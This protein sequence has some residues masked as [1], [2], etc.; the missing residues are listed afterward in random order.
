MANFALPNRS[1]KLTQLQTQAAAKQQLLTEAASLQPDYDAVTKALLDKE[2]YSADYTPVADR[3]NGIVSEYVS[4][5]NKDPFYAFTRKGRQTARV[6]KEILNDPA[7]R[8]YEADAKISDDNYKRAKDKNLGGDYL[9]DGNRVAVIRDGK[10]DWMDIDN[11]NQLDSKKNEGVL[12]VDDDHYYTRNAFGVRAGVPTYSMSS[13]KDV[14]DK[15]RSAFANAG[16]TDLQ[17]TARNTSD[18]IDTA[19][20]RKSNRQQLGIM[21]NNLINKE[22]TKEDLNTLKSKYLQSAPNPSNAGFKQWLNDRVISVA[23]GRADTVQENKEDVSLDLKRAKAAGEA[24]LGKEPLSPAH[25]II[26]GFYSSRPIIREEKGTGTF[27]K[28][29]LLPIK[30]TFERSRGKYKDPNGVEYTSRKLSDLDVFSDA[31]DLGGLLLR[32]PGGNSQGEFKSVPGLANYAVVADNPEAAPALVYEYSY[33]DRSGIKQIIPTNVVSE[34]QAKIKAGQPLPASLEKYTTTV[35]LEQ[36]QEMIMSG[37]YSD[38]QKQV[39]LR[40][41]EKQAQ[42][43][44]YVTTLAR[45]PYVATGVIFGQERNW[46]SED[47]NSSSVDS[48]L[49]T[50]QQAGYKHSTSGEDV[51]YFNNYGGKGS[52]LDQSWGPGSQDRTYRLDVRI[53]L[54]SFQALHAAYGGTVKGEREDTNIG[55][56]GL[57]PKFDLIPSNILDPTSIPNQVGRQQFQT[58]DAFKNGGK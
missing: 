13:I 34:V 26:T 37:D 14:E 55:T 17:G 32:V 39:L 25:G 48:L 53:P 5:F 57:F 10:R 50:I 21:A 11:L 41:A 6:L 18:G 40:D 36:A 46:F 15:I 47:M 3:V 56:M 51:D 43:K 35:P 29:N 58:L 54:K 19:W 23:E 27:T 31:T 20:R 7:L 8:Q 33:T 22:L 28:G 12:T 45:E 30:E 52:V 42:Q 49:E 4:N 16:S 24:Q 38:A 44:G 1:R 9:V 2:L